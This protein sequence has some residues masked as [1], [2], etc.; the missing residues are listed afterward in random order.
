MTDLA[1]DGVAFD[2][3]VT[4]PPYD[5]KSIVSRFGSPTAAHAKG[6]VYRRVSRGFMGHQWDG[7][8]VAFDPATWAAAYAVLKPGGHLAAFGGTRTW[9]RM[10]TAIEDAGFEIRDTL[11]WL[12]GSGFPKSHDVSKQIDRQAGAQR[13]DGAREW[14]GGGRSGGIMSDDPGAVNARVIFDAPATP[15]A[16]EWQGWGTA[17]KPGW[18]PIILVRKPLSE[19]TVARNVLRW[20]TGA[21]NIDRCRVPL[22][23]DDPLHDGIH[24]D[25]GAMDTGA[26][27][28]AWG[29]KRVDRAPG[30]ARHPANVMH[31]GSPEVVDL[32]GPR[33]RFF[34][35]AK[36][37]P[38]DRAGSNHPTVK[39]L[40]LM[41]WLCTMIV[42]PGGRVLD[43]FAGSGSTLQAA[44]ECGFAATGC[45][46]ESQYQADIRFRL[47]MM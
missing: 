26:T 3:I 41:R 35:S 23:D 17:L 5:L 46:M 32:L 14:T 33:T 10:V 40:A 15:E 16:A 28:T 9:H 25:S 24:R 38:A 42:P 29:F 2:A 13:T 36:A 8:G 45:E 47:A 34:Y 27:D 20:G 37:G 4:D 7:T 39:P 30:V 1:L 44:Y 11:A 12:Y 43:P 21:I 19:S 22:P 18:E 6:D 31:D